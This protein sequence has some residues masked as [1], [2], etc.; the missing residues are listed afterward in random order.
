MPPPSPD[1]AVP[2]LL[3]LPKEALG[4]FL[5]LALRKMDPL[6][7]DTLLGDW[8][9]E[10]CWAGQPEAVVEEGLRAFEQRSRSG[11]YYKPFFFDAKSFGFVPPE[12]QL[13]YAEMT[14]WL[15]YGCAQALLGNPGHAFAILDRCLRLLDDTGDDNIVFADELGD[16]MLGSRHDYRSIYEVLATQQT[17]PI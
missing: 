2:Y 5:S 4:E 9:F 1:A 13:W 12:T 14:R 11:A 6:L 10:Q 16:W 7:L 15:D 3:S 17:P 8:Q